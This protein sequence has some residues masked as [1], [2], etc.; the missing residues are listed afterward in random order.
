ML[1]TGRIS[2]LVLVIVIFALYLIHERYKGKLKIEIRTLPAMEALPEAVGRA[3]EMGRPVFAHVGGGVGGQGAPPE[4][5]AS[6]LAGYVIMGEV[7]RLA[8]ERGT[9]LIVSLFQP[10]ALPVAYETV[11]TGFLKGGQPEREP[12]IRFLG[13]QQHAYAAGA[14]G[15]MKREQVASVI[16]MGSFGAEALMLSEAANLAGA[17]VIA[18]TELTY[19]VAM[20]VATCDYSIFGEEMFA[21]SASITKD[22]E[23]VVNLRSRD[24]SKFILIGITLVGSIAALLGSDAVIKLLSW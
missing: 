24:I 19:Q 20:F 4:R 3:S 14:M 7:A 18:G 9:D 6:T 16:L 13:G 15:I 5:V 12:D 11:K 22:P 2:Q 23:E 21:A 10:T 17:L 1:A 8:A